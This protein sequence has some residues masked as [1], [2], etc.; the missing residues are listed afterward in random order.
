MLS[1]LQRGITKAQFDHVGI[2]IRVRSNPHEI[3]FL[4][5]VS[6]GV[7]INSWSQAR[8]LTAHSNN[9]SKKLVYGKVAFRHVNVARNMW[10]NQRMYKFMMEN[11]GKDYEVFGMKMFKCVKAHY[12]N[13]SVYSATQSDLNITPRKDDS[14]RDNS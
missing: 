10:L 14:I 3:F 7:R 13:D 12:M 9:T 6:Q 8:K 11:L 2:I 5:A 4:E 1:K